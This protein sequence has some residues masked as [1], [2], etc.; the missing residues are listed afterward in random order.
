MHAAG[1]SHAR[2]RCLTDLEHLILP[3]MV[4]PIKGK[5]LCFSGALESQSRAEASKTALAAGAKV[6]K[7]VTNSVDIVVCADGSNSKKKQAKE[8]GCDIW[9][10]EQFLEAVGY[11]NNPSA[12]MS[13][14][15]NAASPKRKTAASP[16]TP[17]PKRKKIKLE[18][19][20]PAAVA[21]FPG[22]AKS[23]R[24]VMSAVKNGDHYDVVDDFD[25][26]LMLSESQTS[27]KFYKLQLLCQNKSSSYFVATNWGRL[28]EPGRTQLKG[29]YYDLETG[30]SEF[31]KVFYSKTRNEWDNKKEFVRYGDKYQ[32]VEIADDDADEVTGS[33]GGNNVGQSPLG[34]LSKKQIQKGKFVLQAIRKKILE[35]Q[36]SSSSRTSSSTTTRR[37]GRRTTRN[38]R[39]EQDEI[40]LLSNEFYS[41]IP[42]MTGRKDPPLLNSLE[43][44]HEREVQVE[45]ML[46]S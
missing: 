14:F 35:Q 2:G 38:T 13:K 5:T 17:P 25:V 15:Q 40:K 42:T 1:S 12:V 6:A 37:S 7:S 19:A 20:T 33:G 30:I 24:K 31:G 10:E 8:K 39:Q 18:P 44:L 34:R 9:T 22:S 45:S 43:V 21:A 11:R 29:P 26:K 16:S 41:L 23:Q 4:S 27:N 36:Q 46:S 3:T 28:G 32:I